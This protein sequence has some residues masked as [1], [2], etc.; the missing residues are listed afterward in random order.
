[1]ALVHRSELLTA[2]PDIVARVHADRRISDLAGWEVESA[3]GDAHLKEVVLVRPT[4]GDRVVWP[5]TGVVVK[6]SRDP[7]TAP[8][9]GQIELDRHGFVTT[10]RELRTSCPGVFAAG[11]V[12]AGAY[13]RVSFAM[14]HGS[15]AAR[16]ILRYLALPPAA[17]PGGVEPRP[18]T[19]PP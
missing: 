5:A 13:W 3:Q 16:T 1:V 15:L 10:D 12:V 17:R 9:H 18:D 19:N 6:I 8:F 2:R 4:T 7:R 11:D 14:G